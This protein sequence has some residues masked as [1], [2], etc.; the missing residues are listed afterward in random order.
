MTNHSFPHHRLEVY[1]VAVELVRVV[2]RVSIGDAGLRAQARKSAASAALNCAEGAARN[3]VAD[4]RRVFAIAR[5]EA[6]ECVAAI[7][8]AAA[9]GCCSDDD[10]AAVLALGARVDLMLRR[11]T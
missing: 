5:A 11:L 10:V 6:C 9:L 8:I 2:A 1:R 4:K 3:S 7:E